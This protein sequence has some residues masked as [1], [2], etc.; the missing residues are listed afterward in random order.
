MPS[1]KQQLRDDIEARLR[2]YIGQFACALREELSVRPACALED[3]T[4]IK[5]SAYRESKRIETLGP[6]T[7]LMVAIRYV[8][9]SLDQYLQAANGMATR[10]EFKSMG[11]SL[12][13]V[14]IAINQIKLA[15][16]GYDADDKTLL[17]EWRRRLLVHAADLHQVIS[18]DEDRWLG[19][20]DEPV[21]LATVTYLADRH[22]AS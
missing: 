8:Y 3:R 18:R 5:L 14:E 6:I 4:V 13:G 7:E 11:Q 9:V 15:A 19:A 20:T 16:D 2:S 17:L 12:F 21:R 10:L 1:R 22:A